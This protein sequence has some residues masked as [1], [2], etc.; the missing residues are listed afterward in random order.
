MPYL[1]GTL[2]RGVDPYADHRIKYEYSRNLTSE[3]IQARHLYWGKAPACVGH[4]LPKYDGKNFYPASPIKT[5][6]DSPSIRRAR[7]SNGVPETDYGFS[8]PT[9]KDNDPFRAVAP[10]ETFV[11]ASGSKA[12]S[13]GSA[14]SF[15]SQADDH[16]EQ[17]ERA[18]AESKTNEDTESSHDS[19]SRASLSETKSADYHDARSNGARSVHN[20]LPITIDY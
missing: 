2:P 1:V 12:P 3:E 4:G 5:P 16:S 14:Q 10:K 20:P 15:S 6:N 11:R 9:G 17:F 19:H 8:A 7:I 18:L 13:V